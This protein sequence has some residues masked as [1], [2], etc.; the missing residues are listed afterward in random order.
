VV[1]LKEQACR[2]CRLVTTSETCPGCG[3]TSLTA[4]WS[5]YVV[6]R[7]PENSRIAQRLGITKPGKYALKVR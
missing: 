2:N 3:S 4:D 6:I 7:D 5:G 1:S